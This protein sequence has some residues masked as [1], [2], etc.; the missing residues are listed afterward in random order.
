MARGPAGA[1][2]RLRRVPRQGPRYAAERAGLDLGPYV[3]QAALGAPRPRQR[4]RPPV[5]RAALAQLLGLLGKAGGNLNQLAKHANQAGRVPEADALE[6]VRL[7][8][9]EAALAISSAL[10]GGKIS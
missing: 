4:R 6:A 10:R 9:R 5:E 7:D 3:V 1:D 2:E 8:I